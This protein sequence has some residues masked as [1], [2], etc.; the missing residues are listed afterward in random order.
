MKTKSEF[1]HRQFPPVKFNYHCQMRQ[2]IIPL[3]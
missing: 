2:S 1:R 3:I